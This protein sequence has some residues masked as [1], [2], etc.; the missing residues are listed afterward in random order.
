MIVDIHNHI[1]F[2]V[3]DGPG[4]LEAS[5]E[6]A[7]QA[8]DEGITHVITTPHHHNGK[9]E[10]SPED[11]MN[12][13]VQLNQELIIREIPL[14]ILPGMEIYLYGEIALDLQKSTS[15][16]L[17]LNRTNK[18]VLIELP[19][20]H[21]PAFTEMIFY[22]LQ[23]LGYVPII[24]HAERNEEFRKNPDL[25]FS[26]FQKGALIQVNAEGVLGSYG[27]N[28][29]KFAYKLI[30]HNLVHVLASDAHNATSRDFRLAEAYREIKEEFSSSLINYFQANAISVANGMDFTSHQ[31]EQIKKKPRFISFSFR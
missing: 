17:T 8:V 27:K 14:H 15:P 12:R 5:I 31:P 18:Y 30:K 22:K 1:L 23:L 10:N 7:R 24:A 2:E 16:L 25:L 19:S 3:D 21:Y 20:S 28:I 29:Q 9:Y 11:I 13:V 6:M 26:L 4:T